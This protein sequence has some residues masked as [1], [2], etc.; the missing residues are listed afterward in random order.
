MRSEQKGGSLSKRSREDRDVHPR[1]CVYYFREENTN[2]EK[3][4]KDRPN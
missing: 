1:K 2:K 4:G 3:E